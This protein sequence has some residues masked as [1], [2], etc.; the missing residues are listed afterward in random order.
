MQDKSTACHNM[1]STHRHDPLSGSDMMRLRFPT[2]DRMQG[3]RRLK[4][5][6]YSAHRRM[7]AN[8]LA[9][10]TQSL[11]SDGLRRFTRL[12]C[13]NPPAQ[14]IRKASKLPQPA[15]SDGIH[16][17]YMALQAIAALHG[18]TELNRGRTETRR[19]DRTPSQMAQ[20][21]RAEG[22]LVAAGVNAQDI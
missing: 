4:C 2:I 5:G 15:R 1:S 22:H 8:T 18:H 19:S 17:V 9:V 14:A 7:P 21:E 20:P 12:R 6:R 16:S 3:N 10:V 11:C 13:A